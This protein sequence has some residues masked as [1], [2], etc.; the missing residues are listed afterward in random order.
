MVEERFLT[1]NETSK[2]LKT[3]ISTLNRLIKQ[4]KIPSHKVG[5]RR[6]FDKDELIEWVRSQKGDGHPSSQVSETSG[7]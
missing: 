7:R 5:G 6:L 4:E 3:S 1:A 2:F